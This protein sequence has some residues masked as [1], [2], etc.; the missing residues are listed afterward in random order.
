MENEDFCVY[1]EHGKVKAL[2]WD[3]NSNMLC[4]DFPLAACCQP[5]EDNTNNLAIP[6]GLILLKNSLDIKQGRNVEE[7]EIKQEEKCVD[8][9]VKIIKYLSIIIL[10]SICHN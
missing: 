6:A 8:K 3:I 9:Y 7:K 4:N 5:N 2:G 10:G 1:K